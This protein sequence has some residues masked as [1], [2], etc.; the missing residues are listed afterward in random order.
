MPLSG[1]VFDASTANGYA[2]VSGSGTVAPGT[3]S[4]AIKLTGAS[5]TSATISYQASC[6]SDGLQSPASGTLTIPIT[7]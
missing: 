5:G 7:P 4:A 2:F 3:Q 1:Y 6:G